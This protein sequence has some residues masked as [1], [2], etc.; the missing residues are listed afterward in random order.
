MSTADPPEDSQAPGRTRPRRYLKAPARRR[1]LIDAATEIAG[2][3]GLDR[4]SMVGVAHAAGVSRQ[5]VYEHFPDLSTLVVALLVDRFGE[6]DAVIS[7]AIAHSPEGGIAPAML[8][9][10]EMLSLP[11]EHRHI[12]RT[13]LAHAGI[14]GHE[15]SELANRLRER[16]I[17]RW[18]TLIGAPE[19]MRSRA[20][21]WA[22]TS[23][24]LGLGD[25]VDAGD[26][27]VEQ[28]ATYI[29]TLVRAAFPDG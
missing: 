1:Q 29:E 15:L 18:A 14:T 24:A 5:L 21:A 25:L 16:S 8:A 23:A 26:I 22:L 10:K 6:I 11:A 4:L 17:D 20:L 28:A 27:T 7:R 2:R 19:S 13:L 12:I 3:D 9:A